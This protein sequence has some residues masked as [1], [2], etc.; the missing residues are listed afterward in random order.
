MQSLP[1]MV[2]HVPY[3]LNHEGASASAIRPVKMRQAFADL[4]YE[5]IEISGVS[6]E[7]KAAIAKLKQRIDQGLE[8]QFIYSESSTQPNAF[9][10]P[11]FSLYG[12][13]D[14]AFLA[15]CRRRGIPVGLFYR[16]IYWLY[17]RYWRGI[18]R[19]RRMLITHFYKADL[20]GYRRGV[21][22]LFVPTSNMIELV[23]DVPRER[24]SA[25]PP[26]GDPESGSEVVTDLALFY[27]GGLGP[28]YQLHAC[29][30]GVAQ[31]PQARLTVCVAAQQWQ[32]LSAQYPESAASN[33]NIVHETG[34]SMR[35]LMRASAIGVL[36][37][38]P[39]D[40]WAIAAPMKMFEYL[41]LGKPIVAV[42]GT[43]SGDFVESN[44]I[45][46]A[47]EYSPE[48]LASLLEHLAQHP[49]EIA[50]R[51]RQAQAVRGQHSW[52]ARAEQVV[53]ELAEVSEVNRER[54]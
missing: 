2:Y 18:A 19:W 49:E 9:T 37:V 54:D 41:A 1:V 53:R 27:V 7:R 22:R 25:L 35:A 47:I 20:R 4:G 8:V 16:D 30:A 5:V 42:K 11:Y 50:T 6:R 44:G 21:D 34:E 13:F 32:N 45:G 10:D 33:V 29:V 40:Q 31:V 48:S 3:R 28:F 14:T 43:A 39:V 17:P 26:A 12:Y 23:P 46:W 51:A 36:F 38:E 24:M 52:R 15:W